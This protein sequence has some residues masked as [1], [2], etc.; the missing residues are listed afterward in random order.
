MVKKLKKTINSS[1][2]KNKKKTNNPKPFEN[3][4]NNI[5]IGLFLLKFFVIF[6]ILSTIINLLDLTMLNSW[7]AYISATTSTNLLV[8]P[9]LFVLDNVIFLNGNKFIVTNSCTGLVSASILASVIFSLKKPEIKKKIVL[10]LVGT[11][12]L[13]F[14]NIPRLM[15][16]LL[17][18]KAGFDAELIHIFTWYIMSGLILLIWYYGTKRF[19]NIDDFSELL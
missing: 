1:S 5:K 9:G 7:L 3:N 18:A 6:T 13:L 19:T 4:K 15:L 2:K 14:F 16:V 17:S 12:I 10:L 8:G 11:I